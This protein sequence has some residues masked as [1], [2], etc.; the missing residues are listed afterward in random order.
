MAASC[1]KA[2]RYR[3]RHPV[4]LETEQVEPV[5]RKHRADLPQSES[6]LLHVEQEIAAAADAVEIRR[7]N[8]DLEPRIVR[9]GGR[10]DLLA[11]G[12]TGDQPAFCSQ[13]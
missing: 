4:D 2:A 5:F 11:E 13:N 9:R 12:R 1:G 7:V 3:A 10:D 6:M 8:E